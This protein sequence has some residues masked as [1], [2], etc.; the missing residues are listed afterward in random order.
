MKRK[1]FITVSIIVSISI[2]VGCISMMYFNSNYH[3]S[4]E[5]ILAIRDENIDAVRQIIEEKPTCINIYP[6]ITSKG[7]HSAMNWRVYYPFNEAIAS[8]NI[9]LIEVLIENGADVNCNDGFTP[10]SVAYRSKTENWYNISLI[11]IKNGASLNYTT[12]YTGEKIAVLQDIVHNPPGAWLP[13]YEPDN[14]EVMNAFMYA[15]ESCDHN[16]VEWSW[17][18]RE[19]VLND[20]IEIV[21][22]LLDQKYCDVNDTSVGMTALM[23][24]ARDSTPEIVQLLLD[25]GADKSILSYDGKTAL[26][27][28][29]E[30]NRSEVIQILKEHGAT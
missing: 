11:L 26:D 12:E 14:E 10:L 6:S 29:E 24:A 20:K 3:Y 27:Y 1:L 13:G 23:F 8:G 4:K 9:E 16:K 28:A 22:L 21:K 25:Y 18:L 2:L 17:V 19:S 30:R 5:L 15:L 7:R